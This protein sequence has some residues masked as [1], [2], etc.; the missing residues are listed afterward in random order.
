MTDLISNSK[1]LIADDAP[2]IRQS[3]R[4]TLAQI[5]INRVDTASSVGETR[6]RLRNAEYDVILCD[7]DFGEGMNGQELL[8]EIR[9]S[10]ELPLS[11]VWFMITA[12]A[13]YEKVV[14]VAEVGPDDYLIKPFTGHQLITRL[15]VAWKKKKALQ[16]IFTC[17]EQDNPLGAIE[18]ARLL[19]AQPDIPYKSD[20]L[21][22]LSTLLIES[23]QLDEARILFEEILSTR[24]IP[25]AKL[26]LA[27]VYNKQGNK[28]KADQLLQSSIIENSQYV[29]AYEELANMYMNDGRLDEAMVVFDKCLAITPN[30]ISRL[31]KAGNLANMLGDSGKAKLL[32]SRAVNCGGNS[33]AL[34]ANTILQLAIAAKIEDDL[35]DAEKYLRMVQERVRKDDTAENRISAH[36]ASAIFSGKTEDLSKIETSMTGDDFNMELAISFIMTAHLICPPSNENETPNNSNPPYRWLAIIAKRFVTTKNI[37]GILESTA[38]KRGIWRQFIQ[39]TGQ[40]ITDINNTGV[41]L[42]LK[43]KLEEAVTLLVPVAQSTRNSRLTLSAAHASIKYLKTGLADKDTRTSLLKTASD[44][45]YRLQGHIEDSILLSLQADLDDLL[46]SKPSTPQENNNSATR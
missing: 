43:S 46:S 40:E 39:Q 3:L 26:G 37:S 42:M 6:R 35:G 10:G 17:I 7:Y 28:T 16:P 13:S 25:W 21:R 29:D 19:L 18:A 45:I 4:M 38:N 33:S 5:G 31:Q 23:N 27:K 2:T 30:N 20:L 44:L 41:Q 36:L 12:E 22:L 32:L 34:S 1:V 14:A 9:R 11:S 15:Q 8:E 24:L